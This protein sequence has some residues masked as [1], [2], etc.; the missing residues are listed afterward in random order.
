MAD[1]PDAPTDSAVRAM[2]RLLEGKKRVRRSFDGRRLVY[3]PAIPPE[4]ASLTALKQV[5]RTF[6]NGSRERTV[7]AILSSA[8]GELDAE[9]LDRLADLVDSVRRRVR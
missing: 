6:F 4:R 9:E 5:M 3:E 7:R 2:L 1:L 8:E